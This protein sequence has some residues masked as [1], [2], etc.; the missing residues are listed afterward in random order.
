MT[1]LDLSIVQELGLATDGFRVVGADDVAAIGD[2]DDYKRA[3]HCMIWAPSRAKVLQV[4]D[5]RALVL[6]Q[7]RVDGAL[8]F[9][10]GVL[11]RG[12]CPATAAARE[13]KEEIN[14]DTDRYAVSPS[15]HLITFVSESRKLV[16]HFYALKV[17]EKDFVEIE[18]RILDAADYGQET[19]G[20]FRVPLFNINTGGFETVLRQVFIG[21]AREQLLYGVVRLGIMTVE[22]VKSLGKLPDCLRANKRDKGGSHF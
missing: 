8:G 21:K 3:S 22:E 5:A 16:L 12:E 7:F 2:C 6:M 11:N 9:P 15:Q 10:G 13:M 17:A 1:A 20:F 14:L 4:H 19:L 18:R